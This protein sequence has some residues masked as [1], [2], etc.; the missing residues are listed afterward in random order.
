ML[1]VIVA[2]G[3]SALAAKK[4]IDTTEGIM[5]LGEKVTN[6]YKMIKSQHSIFG[7]ICEVDTSTDFQTL[8]DGVSILNTVADA[9]DGWSEQDKLFAKRLLV[10]CC[11]DWGKYGSILTPIITPGSVSYNCLGQEDVEALV[12]FLNKL[13][14]HQRRRLFEFGFIVGLTRKDK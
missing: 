14:P 6:R 13:S 1:G 10:D 8:M 12:C 11:S 7:V 4:A 5:D 3:V 9:L 2:V